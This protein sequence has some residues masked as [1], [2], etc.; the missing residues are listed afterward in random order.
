M[1]LFYKDYLLKVLITWPDGLD[2]SHLSL[3]NRRVLTES[4][5][6]Y[7]ILWVCARDVKNLKVC[8]ALRPCGVTTVYPHNNTNSIPNFGE[9]AWYGSSFR[10]IHVSIIID[11]SAFLRFGNCYS[12]GG[13]E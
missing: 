8:L 6:E 3:R 2:C 11:K 12:T 5:R 7:Y 13:G 9:S 1:S 4:V 10:D